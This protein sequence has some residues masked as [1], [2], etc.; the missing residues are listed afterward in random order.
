MEGL[1]Q[2]HSDAFSD[3]GP[4]LVEPDQL[5]VRHAF[6]IK[7]HDDLEGREHQG[8]GAANQLDCAA[9]MIGVAV[10]Q[11][12]HSRPVGQRSRIGR[13]RRIVEPWVDQDC[14]AIG[15]GL[16]MEG[17]VAKPGDGGAEA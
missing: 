11:Q 14:R 9:K 5:L 12:N 3:R 16:D 17:T 1:R 2:G 4:T 8:P 10:G 7:F 13:R 6:G 15:L